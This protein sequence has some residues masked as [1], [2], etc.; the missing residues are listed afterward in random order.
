[1]AMLSM[2]RINIYALLKYCKD[3]LET[4]Q[5]RG[6]VEIEN[7]NIEDSVFFKQD[8]DA[9]QA[10]YARS[11]QVAKNALEILD[12]YDEVFH[13]I[14]VFIHSVGVVFYRAFDCDYFIDYFT[15]FKVSKCNLVS[16]R[17]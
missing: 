6:V 1:M 2:Q 11:A 13:D 3:I 16:P 10:Q 5:R 9:M 4:L 17:L 12:E 14:T 7:L 8:T 15:C